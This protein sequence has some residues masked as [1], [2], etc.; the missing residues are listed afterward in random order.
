MVA[1]SLPCLR[2]SC[3]ELT[4]PHVNAEGGILLR[5]FYSIKTLLDITAVLNKQIYVKFHIR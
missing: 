5:K 3:V 2:S 4:C 1:D